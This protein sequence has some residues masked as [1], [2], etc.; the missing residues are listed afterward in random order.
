MTS[1]TILFIQPNDMDYILLNVYK[2]GNLE[3]PNICKKFKPEGQNVQ[4]KVIRT[5]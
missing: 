5:E 2:R 1:V 3:K 4:K